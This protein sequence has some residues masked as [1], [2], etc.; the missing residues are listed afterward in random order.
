MTIKTPIYTIKNVGRLPSFSAPHLKRMIT[1]SDLRRWYK[2]VKENSRC[3]ICIAE[4]KKPPEKFELHHLFR[5]NKKDCVGRF[6]SK[7]D[8][9][10]ALLEMLKCAPL[11]TEH[12]RHIHKIEY[13]T[14]DITDQGRYDFNHEPYKSQILNFRDMVMSKAPSP[15]F[16]G[17]V[18]FEINLILNAGFGPAF[19]KTRKIMRQNLTLGQ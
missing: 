17:K 3:I 9:Q 18:G 15:C 1:L 8:Y 7:R 10:G 12:H 14:G 2:E 16:K 11:C 6:V 5:E 19:F 4:N 13:Q